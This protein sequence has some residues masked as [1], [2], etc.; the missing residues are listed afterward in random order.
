MSEFLWLNREVVPEAEAKISARD[1]GFLHGAGLFET[2]R[3]FGGTVFRYED[4]ID[5]LLAS[6]EKLSM[7]IDRDVLPTRADAEALFEK[8]GL[9]EVRCRLT[10]SAGEVR[11][12]GEGEEVSPTVILAATEMQPYPPEMYSKGMTVC[13]SSYRQGRGDPT[14]GH[15]T[16]NYLSRLIALQEAAGKSCGEALWFTT[17]RLLA[18]GSISN[19]FLVK[20]KV[21]KTPP[22]GT[23]VLPG[24][25]R[26]V[27]MEVVGQAKIS[28]A[29]LPLTINDLLDAD[30]VFLTNS[31]MEVMPVVRIEN[32]AIGEE[33]PGPM[34]RQLSELYGELVRK[35]CT[36]I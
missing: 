25:A 21:L 17:D 4:H 10:C 35:E 9:A 22:V 34:T 5:R 1:A 8:N 29:D 2:I 26:A 31:V 36:G 30:E 16:L 12:E 27:V 13:I 7:P 24:I 19:V 15:K 14:C 33:K 6:A 32:K 23:P 3:A 20:E 28:V 18:E 11:S